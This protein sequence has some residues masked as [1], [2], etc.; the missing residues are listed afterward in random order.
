MLNRVKSRITAGK[1][2]FPGKKFLALFLIMTAY[3][4][5]QSWNSTVTTSVYEPNI[6]KIDLFT[7]RDGNHIVI[8]NSDA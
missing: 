3:I 4:L 1:A 2:G 8:Q 7:N 6:A 5:P